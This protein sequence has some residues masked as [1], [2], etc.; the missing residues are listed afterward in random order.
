MTPTNTDGAIGM[1]QNVPR[2]KNTFSVGLEYGNSGNLVPIFEKFEKYQ[3]TVHA[4]SVQ[5][6]CD[7]F[8]NELMRLRFEATPIWETI[9]KHCKT[10]VIF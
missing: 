5:N 10:A 1:G 3:K 7:A 6:G 8:P 9:Q 4:I 2:P